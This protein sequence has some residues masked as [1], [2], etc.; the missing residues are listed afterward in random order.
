VDDLVDH[1][2]FGMHSRTTKELAALRADGATDADD[3]TMKVYWRCGLVTTVPS[4]IC[5]DPDLPGKVAKLYQ[6]YQKRHP[7][8]QKTHK[9]KGR[10]KK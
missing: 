9:R 3:R 10:S 2:E 5:H 1:I 7:E 8:T 4:G 6:D